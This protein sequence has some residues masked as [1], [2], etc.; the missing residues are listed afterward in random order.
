[1][2]VACL[3][4]DVSTG[5][6]ERNLAA[7][8]AGLADAAARGVELLV[9][10]EMWPT[11][12]T[13]D[14]GDALLAASDAAR[15]ALV[16]DA[17]AAGVAVCGSAYGRSPG[18]RP[19]NRLQ[20]FARGAELL[21]YDKVHLF[22]P[23]AEHLAFDAGALPPAVVEWNGARV[24]GCVC[25]DLRFPELLRVPFQAGVEL[26]LV[27]AQW[28][29]VRHAHWE[30]LVR[31][32]AVESQAFVIACNRTGSAEIGRRRLRLDFPGAS[33]IAGPD[34]AARVVGGADAGLVVGEIDV[35]EARALQ[36]EVPVRK[37]QR[38]DLYRAWS[39]E[40]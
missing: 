36:R 5:A 18:G 31:A 2:R 13:A 25:Y 22:S 29:R 7:A 8:R 10:P 6:P 9:L 23:T 3:Q 14:V 17:A 38:R 28:P 24:S 11:S 16:R 37:D 34:G 35:A 12:F 30:A 32:R 19:T 4:L 1:V 40:G 15:L 20:L 33:M 21:A 39:A 27:A 26:I